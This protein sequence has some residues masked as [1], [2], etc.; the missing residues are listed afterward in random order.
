MGVS[1]KLDQLHLEAQGNRWLHY[2]AIF[3]RVA[4]AAGFITSA[5]VKIMGHRFASGLSAN[6]PMGH[7]LEALHH[8]GYYYTFIGIVQVTAAILL[9]IPR[10]VI[11]G[12]L[13]YFP[14]IL[15]ICILS[16]AVRFEGSI[17]T[18]P[19]MVLADLFLICWKYDKIK[20]ILPINHST[21][22]RNRS[23]EKKLDNR[24]PGKFFLAVFATV[25]VLVLAIRFGF[26]VMPRNSL[27]DCTAQ[28]K[29]TNRTK[30]GAKFCD[31]IHIQGQP[32][33]KSLAE[34]EKAPD[35]STP[36]R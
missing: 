1:N 18:T 26:D 36:A 29:G 19:L 33:D 22:A 34:Y 21:I 11:L 28:F 3:N 15:N 16:F 4:L 20:Y 2:F 30:A 5:M 35:N 7:Y 27:K 24:F 25:M 23:G 10:T 14:V 13:I 12:A 8:T 17:L 32:L 31:C 6:H 9:L